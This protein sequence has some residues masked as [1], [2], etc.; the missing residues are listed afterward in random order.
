MSC[1]FNASCISPTTGTAPDTFGAAVQFFA[2]AQCLLTD[3]P[4]PDDDVTE[5]ATFDF[6]IVGGGSAG[7]VLA[8][9][10]SE[11][12]QWKVLLIEAGSSPP[13]ESSIPG[14]A[15]GIYGTKYD[16]QYYTQFNGVTNK[17]NINK[18]T[19]WPR[20]KMLGGC[21]NI[22]GMLYFRGNS[23]D[24][25]RWFDSGN[26][27]WS[28]RVVKECFKKAESLQDQSLLKNPNLKRFYGTQGP[29][30]IN[31]FNSTYRS[32]T[33]KVLQSWDEIGFKTVEDLNYNNE[34][35][36]GIFRATAFNG[37]RGST[38]HV[39]LNPAR[40]RKNLFV[41]TNTL[42]TKVLIDSNT[43]E[44]NGVEV[45]RDGKLMNVFA[46]SEVILSAGTVNTPQLLMLSGIGPKEHLESKN[47]RCLVNLPAVGKYLQDHLMIPVTIYGDGDSEPSQAERSF[48]SVQYIYNKTGSLAQ[49]S[50][51]DVVAFYSRKKRAG[52]PDFQNHLQ[53][54]HKNSSDL[55]DYLNKTVRYKAVVIDSVVKQNKN[56]TL[57][58]FLFNLLHPQSTGYIKLNSSNPKDH[59]LIYANYLNDTRDIKATVDGIKMLTR[60]VKTKYFRSINGFLGRMSW[61]TCDALE[62]DSDEYWKCIAINMVFTVYH[63]IGTARMGSNKSKS[64]INSRLKV[65]FV[66]KLRVIDASV[67]MSHISGNING[68]VI[69]IAERG[70]N[71][72]KQDYRL[73]QP[74][75]LCN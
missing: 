67:M 24:Y 56:N 22:N 28:P 73:E 38:D 18:Q 68:P 5:G 51:S 48:D 66:K 60:I 58:L 1:G 39:Y 21:S 45:E 29:L 74:N 46:K 12:E 11:V 53:I 6:I 13:V 43:L 42:V 16:W 64:V 71:M 15:K 36:S 10:L 34:L 9:R 52:Y 50:F 27:D 69:M 37:R 14:L 75:D 20:A 2:A 54:F 62:L 19:Y 41:I 55:Q 44:A 8:N 49:N 3:A 35:G 7:C 32:L 70:A 72:I 17:A 47:I 23:L 65:H 33:Q 57:Y 4:I 59:P 40:S 26:I 30:V 61:P 31:T 25:Q 63:P